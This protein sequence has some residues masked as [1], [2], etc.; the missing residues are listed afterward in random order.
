MN[1]I[2]K[3]KR[4]KFQNRF[5]TWLALSIMCLSMVSCLPKRGK[6]NEGYYITK[7]ANIE[8]FKLI[9]TCGDT[10]RFYTYADGAIKDFKQFIYRIDGKTIKL[11][12]VGETKGKKRELFLATDSSFFIA[13][14]QFLPIDGNSRHI[15]DGDYVNYDWTSRNRVE[16]EVKGDSMIRRDLSYSAEK[17]LTKFSYQILGNL[18][19]TESKG[20]EPMT[21]FFQHTYE[22]FIIGGITFVRDTD[23]Q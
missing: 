6:I 13:T 21:D 14:E 22:G 16:V 11:R 1:R 9:R 17:R 4:Q 20:I 18:I 12:G 19:H 3:M 8:R 2:D 5:Y 7:G 23:K 10:L 15:Q